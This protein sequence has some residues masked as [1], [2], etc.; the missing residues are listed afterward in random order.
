MTSTPESQHDAPGDMPAPN[1]QELTSDIQSVFTEQLIVPLVSTSETS[2]RA[3]VFPTLPA[4]GELAKYPAEIQRIIVI[5]WV[6]NRK[7]RTATEARR[8]RFGF[9][10]QVLGLVLGFT[11]ALTVIVGSVHIIVSGYSNEGLL[12][13]GGTVAT[14]AGVFVYAER[15]KS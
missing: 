13:I 1:V 7:H 5:E 10:V 12:G 4:W 15:R 3:Q 9:I 8:Q 11:L 6:E 2:I 14:I